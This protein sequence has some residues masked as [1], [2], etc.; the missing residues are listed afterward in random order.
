[1]NTLELNEVQHNIKI[2][3]KCGALTPN[4]IEDTI[5]TAYGEPI[6]FYMK[7]M[8][9]KLCAFT[10][11]ANKEFLSANV[12]KS[13]MNRTSGEHGQTEKIKQFSTILGSIAPRPHMK[14]PYRS[15]SRVHTDKRAHIFVKAMLLM[16]FESERLIEKTIPIAYELHKAA[17]EN[18]PDQ[19]RFGNIFTSSISNY[20]I[21][22]NYHRDTGN[23]RNTV[24]VIIT[25]RLNATGGCLN[26]PDFNA[27][28]EQADNS[29]LVYP[30]WRNVHGVTPIVPTFKGGYR[31]SLI[32]Y[33]LKAFIGN[34]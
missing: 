19:W 32:F 6:G 3:A 1:M 20:N 24:N 18:V 33:P 22:A 13:V 23:I 10:N 21:S 4:V 15:I 30:A 5:F 9:E 27:T 12:P 16:A 26:L 14:R 25:K 7:Q 2:G 29:I 11:I 17:F 28:I 34:D 8:P 31:N